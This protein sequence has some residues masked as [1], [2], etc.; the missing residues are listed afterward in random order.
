MDT[1]LLSRRHAIIINYRIALRDPVNLRVGRRRVRYKRTLCALV[2]L[3]LFF[4]LIGKVGNAEVVVYAVTRCD[5]KNEF[6]SFFQ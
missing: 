1:E 6:M 2:N 5:L 4:L 3:R